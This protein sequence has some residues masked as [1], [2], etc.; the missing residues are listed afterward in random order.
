[1]SLQIFIIG[2]IIGSFLNLCI[3]RIPKNESIVYPASHC[4][5]CQN[6]IKSYDLIPIMSY[7]ILKGKC[8]YCGEKISINSLIVECLTGVIFLGV[9]LKYGLTI[10]FIKYLF[11]CSF[12]IIIGCIDYNTTDV[13]FS[14]TIIGIIVGIVFILI[15]WYL[16]LPIKT[17]FLAAIIAGMVI[18]LIIVVTGGMGWGDVEICILSGMYL[19][20]RLTIL[21][22]FLS[23]IIGAIIGVLLIVY[24]KKSRKDYIAFGPSIVI[25]T[26]ITI[27]AGENII[28]WYLN[29]GLYL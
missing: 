25:A 11:L 14:T 4:T 17:Y 26:L 13:Y 8:R 5:S 23:F 16:N 12:L 15:N 24:K 21:M 20:V 28:K 3:C 9:Y 7:I 19:G 2:I 22:L 1:M 29:I 18:S 10:E 27:Y 6:K